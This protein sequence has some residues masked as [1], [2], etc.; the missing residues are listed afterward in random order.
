MKINCLHCGHAFGVDDSYCDYEGL[1][2]CPTCGGMLEARIEDGLVKAVRLGFLQPPAER[3][4]EQPVSP[5]TLPNEPT[6]SA[7]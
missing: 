2:R 6:R 7:A 1:L 4:I 3:P 5:M